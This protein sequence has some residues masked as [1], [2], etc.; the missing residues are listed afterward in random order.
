MGYDRRYIVV[1]DVHGNWRD[2]EVLLEKAQYQPG[3]DVLIF[4]GDYNDHLPYPDF[5]VCRLIDR[6]LDL[7][8]QAPEGT[9]F[10]RGNHDLW[11]AEWQDN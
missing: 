4:V 11:F 8:H 9:F 10:V 1:G 7:H 2:T 5:S 6:L 3:Q